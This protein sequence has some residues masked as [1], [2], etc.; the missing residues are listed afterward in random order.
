M[1]KRRIRLCNPGSPPDPNVRGNATVQ[2][3]QDGD[4]ERRD[5]RHAPPSREF[6]K[7]REDDEESDRSGRE[8][9]ALTGPARWV[10][11]CAT[12]KEHHRDE[13]HGPFQ[14]RDDGDDSEGRSTTVDQEGTHEEGEAREGVDPCRPRRL[15]CWQT[16]PQLVGESPGG[17]GQERD[18][19]AGPD[20]VPRGR[21]VWRQDEVDEDGRSREQ[22]DG[23]DIATWGGER[24]PP[25]SGPDPLDQEDRDRDADDRVVDRQPDGPDPVYVEPPAVPAECPQ[26][27]PGRIEERLHRES[28]LDDAVR[29]AEEQ[30]ARPTGLPADR[31]LAHDEDAGAVQPD[32]EEGGDRVQPFQGW[33]GPGEHLG[34]HRREENERE[35]RTSVWM[36]AWV[37][38]EGTRGP[39]G[40]SKARK[41]CCRARRSAEPV[42]PSGR[43]RFPSKEKLRPVGSS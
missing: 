23:C 4:K 35:E 34:D 26:V 41:Q 42:F 31:G 39:A 43:A 2:P 28:F 21:T 20:E 25:N 24:S 40:S 11:R 16:S 18:R 1:P 3:D 38:H 27:H 36:R 5:R 10:V 8:C 9:E 7:G 22:P 15:V 13:D 29:R 37:L 14:D 17:P 30:D 6:K 19:G 32:Q 33:S 12:H